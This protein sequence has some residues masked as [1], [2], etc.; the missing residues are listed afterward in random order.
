ME[1][2]FTNADSSR[3]AQV[4]AIEFVN[5]A[6]FNTT[7]LSKIPKKIEGLYFS[8]NNENFVVLS[9]H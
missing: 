7:R 9:N 1:K 5:P 8:P 6:V 3:V 4:N 2:T